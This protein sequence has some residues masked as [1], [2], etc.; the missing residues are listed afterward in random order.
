MVDLIPNSAIEFIDWRPGELCSIL[1]FWLALVEGSKPEQ[2]VGFVEAIEAFGHEDGLA[3]KLAL[4]AL[5]AVLDDETA[6]QLV[7]GLF[8]RFR[9]Q[10]LEAVNGL[11]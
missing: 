6:D 9:E 10:L 11:R 4:K 2:L 5:L 3:P 8:L 1:S 7:V